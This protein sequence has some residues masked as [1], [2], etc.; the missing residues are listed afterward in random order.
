[1]ARSACFVVIGRTVSPTFMSAFPT[2]LSLETQRL[3]DISCSSVLNGLPDFIRQRSNDLDSIY[4]WDTALQSLP[5]SH[6]ASRRIRKR[7]QS[8]E[9]LRC[10]FPHCFCGVG[11]AEEG[12]AV[13]TAVA[14]EA[15]EKIGVSAVQHLGKVCHWLGC[16]RRRTAC[17]CTIEQT[18]Q[19]RR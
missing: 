9:N 16:T 5:S 11:E 18:I 2:I 14:E 4:T 7:Y 13:G 8:L 1:M 12:L 15:L 17:V 3:R 19:A 10:A 6:P